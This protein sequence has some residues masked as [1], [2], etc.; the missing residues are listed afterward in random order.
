MEC[1]AAA[2]E[3][4]EQREAFE[5]ISVALAVGAKVVG[6]AVLWT[7]KAALMVVCLAPAAL[8]NYE[9]AKG[10]STAWLAYALVSV[11]LATA[12]V[13]VAAS[14]RLSVSGR[15]FGG[16]LALAFISQ[17]AFNA[18]ANSA[19]EHDRARDAAAFSFQEKARID[20][21]LKECWTPREPNRSPSLET[22]PSRP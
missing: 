5:R 12:G 17:N 3:G 11:A 7:V 9:M 22:L 14:N 21:R 8:V 6:R 18:I 20:A 10:E 19:S 1:A 2:M 4:L 13:M 15:V 16:L